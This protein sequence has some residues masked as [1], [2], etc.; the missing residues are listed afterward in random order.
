M[1]VEILAVLFYLTHSTFLYGISFSC[2]SERPEGSTSS[3]LHTNTTWSSP[4][5]FC[6]SEIESLRVLLNS[7]DVLP[8]L[9]FRLDV[10]TSSVIEKM[11][12]K[13]GRVT[14]IWIF[15][16]WLHM[17]GFTGLIVPG[18]YDRER[19]RE[20]RWLGSLGFFS[21]C[22]RSTTSHCGPEST[23]SF[24]WRDLQV[25]EMWMH[26]Y[27]D[28]NSCK[29]FLLFPKIFPVTQNNSFY[30]TL[31]YNLHISQEPW[32]LL[33]SWQLNNPPVS[34]FTMFPVGILGFAAAAGVSTGAW[35][36]GAN[37]RG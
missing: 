30:N 16:L 6:F 8:E 28:I 33:L 22:L 15:W 12:F 20:R 2:S 21:F 27:H 34:F 32:A 37:Q 5:V 31:I 19:C 4:S 14:P 13:E 23:I 18:A 17:P 10:R 1:F 36:T 9:L 26:L 24:S 29:D 3:F 25:A 11:K 7:L 35:P